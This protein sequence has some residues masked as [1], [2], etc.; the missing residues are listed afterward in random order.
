MF[1]DSTF[2]DELGDS[3]RSSSGVEE[4]EMRNANTQAASASSTTT[5]ANPQDTPQ[6]DERQ[7]IDDE[8]EIDTNTNSAT[9]AR[10]LIASSTAGAAST[11]TSP[12]RSQAQAVLPVVKPSFRSRK[13]YSNASSS[14]HNNHNHNHSTTPRRKRRRN[15]QQ[16]NNRLL[17]DTGSATSASSIA[18]DEAEYA[19]P[20]K[21]NSSACCRGSKSTMN[22]MNIVARIVLW[23]TF[24]SLA[25]AVIWYSYELFNHGYVQCTLDEGL[26]TVVP[27]NVV[28]ERHDRRPH[29]I[30]HESE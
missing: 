22:C 18:G 26:W 20:S 21:A 7:Q 11:T 2:L 29:S 25:A 15:P 1:G 5:T 17:A 3:T 23:L 30:Y 12:T 27:F 24:I 4:T 19:T 8:N 10:P 6:S 28:E 9:E 14:S 16:H 13:S